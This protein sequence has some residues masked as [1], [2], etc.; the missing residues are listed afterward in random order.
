MASRLCQLLTNPAGQM[1]GHSASGSACK[2]QRV[3]GAAKEEEEE[4]EEP[5]AVNHCAGSARTHFPSCTRGP[6]PGIRLLNPKPSPLKIKPASP[7]RS[8]HLA[9][10][11]GRTEQLPHINVQRF[12]GGF[13][14]KAHRLVYHSTLG[15]RVIKKKKKKGTSAEGLTD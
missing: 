2:H 8:K 9:S 12:R 4:E 11:S 3:A 5:S 15:L 14:C 1:D 6:P 10:E 13:V 7:K